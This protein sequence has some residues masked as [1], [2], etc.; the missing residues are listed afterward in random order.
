MS[1]EEWFD[2]YDEAMRPIGTAARSEVHARGH[3]HRSF[4]CWLARPADGGLMVRFQRR[5]SG[6]DTFPDCF[7]ITVAGHLAA[8]ETHRDAA[9][10]IREEIG[11]DIPFEKLTFLFE[12]RSVREGIARG[13][14]FIDREISRVY[15]ALSDAPLDSF[16]LQIEETAGIYEADADSLIALFEGRLPE[17]TAEGRVPSAGG[18]ELRPAVERVTPDLFVPREPSYYLD[19]FRRLQRLS[20]PDRS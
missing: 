2:I 20:A 18:R 4:H 14:P 3:W 12:H 5:A 16:R 6:K 11:L 8:G 10:E 17:L 15:G 1:D 9:R 13:V 7:D 19:V